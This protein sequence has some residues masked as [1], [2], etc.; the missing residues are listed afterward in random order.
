MLRFDADAFAGLQHPV[1]SHDQ[2][3]DGLHGD[4]LALGA[5]SFARTFGGPEGSRVQHNTPRQFATSCEGK[6]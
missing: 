6:L 2:E 1:T 5:R 4:L 3:T